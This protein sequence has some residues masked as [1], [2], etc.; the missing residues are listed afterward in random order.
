MVG[1]AFLGL[2]EETSLFRCIHTGTLH[3]LIE[4]YQVAVKFGAVY[5]GKLDLV[6][7]HETAGAAHAG[8]VDHDGVHTDDGLDTQ[9]LGQK[10]YEFHHDHGADGDNAVEAHSVIIQL[11]EG[12]CD[13]AVDAVG[14]V[15]CADMQIGDSAHLILEDD[16]VLSLGTLDAVDCHAVIMEPLQLAVDRSSSYAACDE[17][18]FHF[19][20]FFNGKFSQIGRFSQRSYDI[21]EAVAFIE[22]RHSLCLSADHLE[23]DLYGACSWIIITDCQLAIRGASTS[24]RKMFGARFSFL[25]ILNM[26]SSYS[27]YIFIS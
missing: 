19:L 8:A 22:L 4:I 25:R 18:D 11:L 12:N 24:I 2:Q 17:A 15:I 9:L 16:D 7:D 20:E 3:S 10:T 27:E 13:I 23:Y 1:V 26:F 21:V 6:A 5:T 14:A